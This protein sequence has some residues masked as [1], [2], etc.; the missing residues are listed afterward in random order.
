MKKSC[1]SV[2]DVLG[3]NSTTKQAQ[4]I[5]SNEPVGQ[6]FLRD[7]VETF[8]YALR[9]ESAEGPQQTLVLERVLNFLFV[10]I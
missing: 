7:L 3:D 1:K 4:R 10:Q 6:I 9:S 2:L 8:Q 5:G